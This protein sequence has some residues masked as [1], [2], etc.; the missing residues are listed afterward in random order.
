MSVTI[1]DATAE[2]IGDLLP[3]VRQVDIDEWVL[4]SGMTIGAALRRA[5]KESDVCRVA[6][7][8]KSGEPFAMFYSDTPT[9]ERFILMASA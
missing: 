8:G 1:R 2:D 9:A 3:L 6:L 7:H 4:A 5:F